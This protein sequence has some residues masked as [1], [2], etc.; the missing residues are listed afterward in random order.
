MALILAVISLAGSRLGDIVP[1][2]TAQGASAPIRIWAAV[3]VTS[4]VLSTGEHVNV[5]FAA[6]NL[7]SKPIPRTAVRE[8][9]VLVVNGEE[10][11][12]SAFN[13][14]NG[15]HDVE[16]MLAPGKSQL[17]VCQLTSRFDKPGLYR[18]VWKGKGFES[19]PFEFRIADRP[20]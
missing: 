1:I 20:Y 10:W 17:F 15:I 2:V 7:G 3:A 19:L 8:E 13:F 4:P 14:A 9:T 12:D 18:L 5:Y 6:T 16:T 11:K